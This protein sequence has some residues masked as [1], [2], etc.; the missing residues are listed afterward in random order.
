MTNKLE[1]LDQKHKELNNKFDAIK[2]LFYGDST[3]LLPT[4]DR[5][6]TL[7]KNQSP[8]I[9]ASKRDYMYRLLHDISSAITEAHLKWE[10]YGNKP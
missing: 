7:I 2:K 10:D 4:L 5:L 1:E 6:H 8:R 3:G 9:E